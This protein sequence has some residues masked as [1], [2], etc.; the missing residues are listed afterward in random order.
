MVI[1]IIKTLKDYIK[2][3]KDFKK[4]RRIKISLYELI[5]LRNNTKAD[6]KLFGKNIKR[7]DTYWYL[8]SL[9][10]LFIEEVYQF[11]SDSK[12][13]L[14][15]DCG[16]N[17]GLSIIYFK[18]QM[19]NAKIIGFEPDNEIFK[20]LEININQF[21]FKDV[22]LHQKAVWINN[23]P[24]FFKLNGNLSGHISNEI[25]DNTIPIETQRLKDLLNQNVDFLKIDIEGA[26]YE[27]VKDCEENLKNVKNIFV[28]YHSFHDNDQMIGELLLILK[29][30]GFKIYLKEAWENMKHPFIE[31]Q[32]PYFDLQLNI[33]GYRR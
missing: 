5:K 14:I 17:I 12:I 25:D 30:S 19:P 16:S 3:I 22:E 9:N 29:K 28:E 6:A 2:I 33:F 31:K 11:E 15:I 27:I 8:H 1:E 4:F 21:G 24:L 13:P 10:E 18:K 20:M 26:E 7:T 32:G 23:D